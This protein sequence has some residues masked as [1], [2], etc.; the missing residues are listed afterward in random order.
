MPRLFSR[1][2]RFF[3]PHDAS[4]SSSR[5]ILFIPFCT[6]Q[7]RYQSFSFFVVFHLQ[8]KTLSSKPSEALI[9]ARL[10]C[11]AALSLA[12]L[13]TTLSR[14]LEWPCSQAPPSSAMPV[15]LTKRSPALEYKTTTCHALKSPTVLISEH[16][17]FKPSAKP[18]PRG[19]LSAIPTMC[20]KRWAASTP[21]AATSVSQEVSADVQ[22]S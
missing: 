8:W 11:I 5:A 6:F 16:R 15:L 18:S 21:A 3:L 14:L 10:L 2:Y 9:S 12:C 7:P 13:S 17:Q 1:L 22:N 4:K 19:T 20:P